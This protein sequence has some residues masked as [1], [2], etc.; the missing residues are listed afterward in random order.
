M[1][2]TISFDDLDPEYRSPP[3]MA[4]G[5]S[6]FNGVQSLSID[7]HRAGWS[8]VRQLGSAFGWDTSTPDY[9]REILFNLEKVFRQEVTVG[10]LLGGIETNAEAWLNGPPWSS[11]RYFDCIGIAGAAIGDLATLGTG[12]PQQPL[13]AG[14]ALSRARKAFGLFKRTKDLD[15]RIA[16]TLAMFF[17]LNTAFILNPTGMKE[18]D[19]ATPLELAALRRPERLFIN[20]GSNEGLFGAGFSGR[21]NDAFKKK[22][23]NVPD[24]M[25][26]LGTQLMALPEETRLIYVNN[27]IKPRTIA[28]LYT[29]G[30]PQPPYPGCNQY[31]NEYIG[32][33]FASGG[34]SAAVM[35]EIDMEIDAVNRSV[36]TIL[37]GMDPRITMVDIYAATARHDRKHEC[38]NGIEI[39]IEGRPHILD[40]T[41]IQS[42]PGRYGGLF[43]LDNMH[44]TNVGY[45]L[46][47]DVMA[48]SI[49]TREGLPIQHPIDYQAAFDADTLLSDM[50]SGLGFMYF[51]LAFAGLFFNTGDVFS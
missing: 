50:P 12:D 21:W 29:R 48:R 9:P 33:F 41:P 7:A 2:M 34:I 39:T 5:D 31:Y 36:A 45:A 32:K 23:R 10:D 11:R 26:R 18:L 42:Q 16:H 13:R 30:I 14:E 51:L 8:P 28:N 49:N 25:R 46:L 35:R 17:N 24:L 40:N 44:P 22:L 6:I 20:I 15:K 3:L 4:I 47:A 1:T 38:G 43:S 27:L 37:T 19:T